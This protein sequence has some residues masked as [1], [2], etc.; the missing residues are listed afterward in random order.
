MVTGGGKPARTYQAG[1]KT[2]FPESQVDADWI[3]IRVT[4][5]N[6]HLLKLILKAHVDG[7]LV[8]DPNVKYDWNTPILIGAG[9]EPGHSTDYDAVCLANT[10]NVKKIINLSNIDYVY[11]SDPRTNPH[12]KK[13]EKMEWEEFLNVIP[14]EW[15]PGLNSPFDPTAARLAK[16]SE[17]EVA[18]INGDHLDRLAECIE[19]KEFIGT[20]IY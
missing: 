10:Y 8:T 19:G 7:E 14:K 9:Y 15:S 17:I 12:A 4:I 5:L 6:A 13:I 2:F 3:G 11:D 18:M 16:D 20:K 1:I